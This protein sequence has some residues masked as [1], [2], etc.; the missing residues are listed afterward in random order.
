MG[1][2][3]LVRFGVVAGGSELAGD[4]RWEG[5]LFFVVGCVELRSL[6]LLA[7]KICRLDEFGVVI[8]T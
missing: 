1:E 3:R 4:C 7:L 5:R 6:K 8:P 2:R